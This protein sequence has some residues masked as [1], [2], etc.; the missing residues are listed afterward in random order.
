MS[1]NYFHILY[2]VDTINSTFTP[3]K[4]VLEK[5]GPKVKELVNHKFGVRPSSSDVGSPDVTR[6]M[7]HT[8]GVQRA[9]I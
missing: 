2:R 9:P 8:A 1:Y 4:M 3:V 6:S 5:L 7:P